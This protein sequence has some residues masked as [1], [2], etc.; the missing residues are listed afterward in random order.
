MRKEIYPVLSLGS[1][2]ADLV[3]Q[4]E[5]NCVSECCGLSAYDFSTLNVA[6]YFMRYGNAEIPRSANENI[7]ADL[8]N[9][10]ISTADLP[11]SKSGFICEIDTV[12]DVCSK[13]DLDT[14][15]KEIRTSLIAAPKIIALS[16]KSKFRKNDKS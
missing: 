15:F 10:E 1:N 3:A 16:E 14:F 7:E 12:K 13:D 2:L 5:T 11:A 8:K 4:C 6:H 9:L